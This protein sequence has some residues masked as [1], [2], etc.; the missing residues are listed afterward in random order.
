[1]DFNNPKVGGF[2]KNGETVGVSPANMVVLKGFNQQAVG[3]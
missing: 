1:M 2:T 3:F